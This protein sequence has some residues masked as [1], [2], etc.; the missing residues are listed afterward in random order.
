MSLR[1][2]FGGSIWQAKATY[3]DNGLSSAHMNKY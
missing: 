1:E 2:E 3:V